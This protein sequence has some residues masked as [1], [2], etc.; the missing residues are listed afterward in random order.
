MAKEET[1]KAQKALAEMKEQ[2]E[3]LREQ[4]KRGVLEAKEWEEA[5]ERAR[6]ELH[7][8]Q[9]DVALREEAGIKASIL[10]SQDISEQRGAFACSPGSPGARS[11]RTSLDSVEGGRG[12][13]GEQE[14]SLPAH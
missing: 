7:R 2:L 1:R 12:S 5:C 6:E 11:N 14:G 3:S 10:R 8:L 4:Q 9:R 13:P